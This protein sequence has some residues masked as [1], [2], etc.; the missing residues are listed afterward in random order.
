MNLLQQYRGFIL[1]FFLQIFC[2]GLVT[3]VVFASAQVETNMKIMGSFFISII[4]FMALHFRYV[5]MKKKFERDMQV[6]T[7]S[8]NRLCHAICT[9]LTTLSGIAEIFN[10]A[11]SNLDSEQRE[12]IRRLRSSTA[13]LRILITQNFDVSD[14][15]SKG[16]DC[17]GSLQMR[18]KSL[19]SFG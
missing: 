2:F 9:P 11:Q 14:I 3:A 16:P 13:A 18:F 7:D 1:S 19:F 6:K 5:C 17:R 4:L 15:E 8:I 10:D 12:L